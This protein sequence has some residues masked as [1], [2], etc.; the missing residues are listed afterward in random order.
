MGTWNESGGSPTQAVFQATIEHTT[1]VFVVISLSEGAPL[2]ATIANGSTVFGTVI[3][4]ILADP[5]FTL[6]SAYREYTPTSANY[7]P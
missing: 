7:A 6:S 5:D 3:D 4:A 2:S 1:G